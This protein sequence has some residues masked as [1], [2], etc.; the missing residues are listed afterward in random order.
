MQ[1]ICK[2]RKEKI[3]I[4]IIMESKIS[5]EM[6]MA[7]ES[8]VNLKPFHKYLSSKLKIKPEIGNIIAK[9]GKIAQSDKEKGEN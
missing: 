9:N 2:P 7:K 6:K 1:D 5:F 4:H 8:K 3:T